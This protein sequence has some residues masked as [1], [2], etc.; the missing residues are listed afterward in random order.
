[1]KE[2]LKLFIGLTWCI[3]C[4]TITKG[5]ESNSPTESSLESS[6]SQTSESTVIKKTTTTTS[7]TLQTVIQHHRRS[8]SV[9]SN[10]SHALQCT[11]S[12]TES[13]GFNTKSGLRTS[14]R[15]CIKHGSKTGL[16]QSY[17]DL[18]S[19]T[20]NSS[21]NSTYGFVRKPVLKRSNSSVSSKN[22]RNNSGF[23]TGY[24]TNS[25][26]SNKSV[27]FK[28]PENSG[29]PDPQVLD[30]SQ[31]KTIYYFGSSGSGLPVMTSSSSGSY[32][33]CQNY[34]GSCGSCPFTQSN[35]YHN[36]HPN[37]IQYALI[38]AQNFFNYH[39]QV[40]SQQA[41][42]STGFHSNSCMPYIFI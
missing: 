31:K 7:A 25:L 20:S 39:H 40:T 1:M 8:A 41:L 23:K 21:V 2:N 22:N 32:F 18:L 15:P 12:D 19:A 27:K 24:S 34:C 16:S 3:P 14:V 6:E 5:R 42:E 9:S 4:V 13:G 38:Q 10:C 17:D 36:N 35:F 26:C 33:V 29:V 37:A 11:T 28:L 30:H